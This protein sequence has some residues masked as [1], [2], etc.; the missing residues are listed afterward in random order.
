MSYIQ[1]HGLLQQT[2]KR[3]VTITAENQSIEYASGQPFGG[4]LDGQTP[5]SFS[6]WWKPSNISNEGNF[7][8]THLATP[9]FRGISLSN[10]GGTLNQFRFYIIDDAFPGDT[11]RVDFNTGALSNGTWYHVVIT[12]AGGQEPADCNCYIDA[13]SLTQ[14]P[15]GELD[16]LSG[17]IIT[18]ANL[19]LFNGNLLGGAL[20]G[21]FDEVTWWD[22]ALSAGEISQLYN[23]GIPNNPRTLPF[24][25]NLVHWLRFDED[26]IFYPD[27]YDSQGT[28]TPEYINI[29]QS[30]ITTDVLE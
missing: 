4:I 23:S 30:A 1:Q 27:A 24:Q 17:G 29:P 3:S 13:V 7:F 26:L 18:T 9:P 10:R 28:T 5:F 6:V 21:T 2:I 25:V 11:L 8:S 14:D 19:E 22:K 16:N 15:A 20:L 12:Y